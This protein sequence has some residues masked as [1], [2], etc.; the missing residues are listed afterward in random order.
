[1]N[2]DIPIEAILKY[3]KRDRDTYKA[4]VET[5]TAY[6]HS[7]EDKL[8]KTDKRDES[9]NNTIEDLR[10]QLAIYREEITRTREDARNS[11]PYKD[12]ELALR[13]KTVRAQLLEVK[14]AAVNKQLQRMQED[15]APDK[16]KRKKFLIF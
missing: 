15:T 1:M 6:A 16:P 7:L 12:L 13:G 10:R 8:R 4:K 14:L 9:L 3:I 11:K 5:L 2:E